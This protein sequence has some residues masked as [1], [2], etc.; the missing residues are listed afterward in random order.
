MTESIADQVEVTSFADRYFDQN[1]LIIRR[2]DTKSALVIDIDPQCNATSGLGVE[3][4]DRV[5]RR[6]LRGEHQDRYGAQLAAQRARDI[7][8]IPVGQ[9]DV[10]DERVVVVREREREA[11]GGV[12]RGVHGVPLLAQYQGDELPDVGVILDDQQLGHTYQTRPG[13]S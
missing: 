7:H 2:Q 9:A 13:R 11:L 12:G 6:P 5:A 4:A 8:P 10:E 3:P 1:C